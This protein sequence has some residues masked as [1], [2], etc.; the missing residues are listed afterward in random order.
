MQLFTKKRVSVIV[1]GTY[2][3]AVIELIENSGASGFTIYEGIGGKGRHGMKKSRGGV[4]DLSGN[5]EVVTITSPGVTDRI[6][7]E[8]QQMMDR[9]IM[10]VVHVA[11]V[12]VIRDRHF[13]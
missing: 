1:E 9:G 3:D 12:W 13:S 8:L 2:K 6:L 10:L 4:G 11:D 7:Q 5:V